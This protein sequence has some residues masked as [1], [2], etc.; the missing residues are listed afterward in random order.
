MTHTENKVKLKKLTDRE[1]FLR[2]LSEVQSWLRWE[3]LDGIR[4]EAIYLQWKKYL[5]DVR[6]VQAY[7]R[8]QVQREALR[9]GDFRTVRGLAAEARKQHAEQSWE[10]VKPNFPNPESYNYEPFVQDYLTVTREIAN[11]KK[12]TKLE[13]EEIFV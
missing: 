7:R 1:N 9:N 6:G 11:L 13:V 4:K 2:S 12:T 3:Q 8:Y 5:S 10:L